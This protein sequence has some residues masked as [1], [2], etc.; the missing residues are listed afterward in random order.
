MGIFPN[1]ILITLK[2]NEEHSFGSLFHR[3]RVYDMI[4]KC[5]TASNKEHK[6]VEDQDK[7]PLLRNESNQKIIE[8]DDIDPSEEH[9]GDTSETSP[10]PD[11]VDKNGIHNSL[12]DSMC[13][14]QLDGSSNESWDNDYD[15]SNELRRS[16]IQS[17]PE[18]SNS[19]VPT[20]RDN[21]RQSNSREH[22]TQHLTNIINEP[23]NIF[24]ETEQVIN[25]N[26]NFKSQEQPT[27]DN[28]AAISAECFLGLTSNKVEPTLIVE[29]APPI[30]SVVKM[31]T[32]Q[33]KNIIS[34]L[35]NINIKIL[36]KRI[37][38]LFL[39]FFIISF[40][41]PGIQFPNWKVNLTMSTVFS[42]FDLLLYKFILDLSLLIARIFI[43]KIRH[44]VVD[45]HTEVVVNVLAPIV[46]K[47]FVSSLIILL[48]NLFVPDFYISNICLCFSSIAL[49]V[50]LGYM[51]E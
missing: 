28:E 48:A 27:K 3:D 5:C 2:S 15:P 20:E 31:Q 11:S 50:T 30:R 22:L 51:S 4:R 7:W 26:A 8:K 32:P 14:T 35:Q 17:S 38:V 24:Q 18:K 13:D 37:T 44:G 34:L 45:A 49:C 6:S 36:V 21:L 25:D 9:L 19:Q 23:Q 42:T 46:L 39:A 47:P 43:T 1:S 40:I 10:K 41:T 29:P 33:R 12:V 16:N